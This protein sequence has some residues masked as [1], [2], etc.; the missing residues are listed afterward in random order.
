MRAASNI[1]ALAAKLRIAQSGGGQSHIAQLVNL[2]CFSASGPTLPQGASLTDSGVHCLLTSAAATATTGMQRTARCGTQGTISNLRRV[3]QSATQRTFSDVANVSSSSG[4][5]STI[6]VTKAAQ[7]SVAGDGAIQRAL[8]APRGIITGFMQS[9]N[10]NASG[11]YAQL[12]DKVRQWVVSAKQ[13]GRVQLALGLQLESFW[14]SH[15]RKVFSACGV[16][17]VYVLW[18]TLFSVTSIFVNLSETMAELGFLSLSVAIVAFGGLY[19]R[20]RY[21]ISPKAAYRQAMI[22]LNTHPSV[23]EVM[24]APL[25]GS[26]VRAQVIT[27]G[28]LRL[29]ALQPSLRSRRLHMIFPLRGLHHRGLVSMEVKR[30]RGKYDFKLLAVDIPMAAGGEQRIF[31]AGDEAVYNRGSVINELRDPFLQAMTMAPVYERED[32]AD[33][34]ADDRAEEAAEAERAAAEAAAVPKSMDQG[35]GMYV[36]ERVVHRVRTALGGMPIPAPRIKVVPAKS[37]AGSR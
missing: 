4:S 37:P 20:H 35:G 33:E 5:G 9:S 25:A 19:L 32:E 36:W 14:Q 24:G 22:R 17:A 1:S 13:P 11:S 7:Q 10:R 18:K 12:P 34:Q 3:L 2:R 27:G 30:R 16:L 21:T 8:K 26:D 6:S 28:G 23:L 15:R 29:K 31:L